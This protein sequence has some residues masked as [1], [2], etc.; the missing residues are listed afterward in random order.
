MEIT[1]IAQLVTAGKN[2]LDAG[3]VVVG[4][5]AADKKGRL[6]FVR[7]QRV[8]NA[9]HLVRSPID[10]EHQ[11]NAAR[12]RR[13]GAIDV[14]FASVRR[15]GVLHGKQTDKSHGK[16]EKRQSEIGGDVEFYVFVQALLFYGAVAVMFQI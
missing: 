15:H 4:P 5:A 11:G 2:F 7:L 16:D 9:I 3:Y 10:V 13:S 1:V 12:L 14:F 6:C 8:E